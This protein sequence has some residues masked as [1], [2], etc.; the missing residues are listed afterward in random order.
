MPINARFSLSKEE[1]TMSTNKAPSLRILCLH[2]AHSS[3]EELYE[4]M[5]VMDKRL[6]EKHNVELVYVNSPL[7]D[8]NSINGLVWWQEEENDDKEETNQQR[9]IGLDATLLHVKQVL[10]SMPFSGLLAVGQGAAL[11]SLLPFLVDDLE[12]CIFVN[13]YSLLQEEERLVDEDWPVLH[14]V[15]T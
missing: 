4:K 14:I 12:F 9:N 3:A 15:G 1:K 6:F 13:G 5:K 11:G 2:D 7:L 10:A 8:T